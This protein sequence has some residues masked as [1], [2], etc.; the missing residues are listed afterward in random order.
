MKSRIDLS[1]TSPTATGTTSV[2]GASNM[3][4]NTSAFLALLMDEHEVRPLI[5]QALEVIYEDDDIRLK[6]FGHFA[7]GI[8]LADFY[9][10][11]CSLIRSG[12]M[13]TGRFELMD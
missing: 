4:V 9:W 12:R 5:P 1:T 10:V 11:A 7:L 2:T 8:S 3:K 6:K 13:K